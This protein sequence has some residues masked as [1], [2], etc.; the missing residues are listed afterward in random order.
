[1]GS[2]ALN[3]DLTRRGRLLVW[4]ASGVLVLLFP[5]FFTGGPGWSSSPLVRSAWNL[6]HPLFFALLTLT[7]RPW[8]FI[9]GW[10][11]WA[12][13]SV[14]VFLLGLGVELAQSLDRREVDSQDIFRNLTG[15]WAVL[16]LQSQI[17]FV[18]PFPLRDWLIR[19]LAASLLAIDLVSVTRIAIQ[20]VQ[21]RLWLPDLYDFQQDNPERFWRGNI[22]RTSGENCGPGNDS[23]LIIALTT[24]R[25]SG[26]SLDNLPPDWRG[27]EELSFVLWNPQTYTIP[28]TLRIN[29]LTHEQVSNQYHDRFNRQYRIEPGANIIRQ[30]LDEIA[31]APRDRR[32]HMDDIRRLMFFTSD[33]HLPGDLC[34]STLGLNRG[35]DDTG[36]LD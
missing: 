14:I 3:A 13:A 28:L 11:L 1:M 7:V 16:S 22:T 26:A 17:G 18:R 34:L 27:Y 31:E 19:A 25:Y 33:L 21:I 29:D 4:L 10:K 36:G 5:L 35:G 15:L 12:L 8:R 30:S 24:S 20:Q 23:G 9:S 6:G 2:P 32:M